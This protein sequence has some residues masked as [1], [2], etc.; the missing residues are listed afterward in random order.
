MDILKIGLVMA[1]G[2]GSAWAAREA[3]DLVFGGPATRSFMQTSEQPAPAGGATAPAPGEKTPPKIPELSRQEMEDE[4]K[5]A[6]AEI[7]NKPLPGENEEFRPS[8]PLAA[9]VAIALPSDI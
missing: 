2:L 4:L 8:K 9:D 6:Q 7:N 1:A 5:R 3:T